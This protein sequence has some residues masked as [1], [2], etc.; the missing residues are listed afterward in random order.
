VQEALQAASIPT[1]MACLVH[2]TGER[3]WIEYP[4]LPKRDIALFADPTGGLPAEVQAQVRDAMARV[5]EELADGRR[6]LA[7]QPDDAT[8]LAVMRTIIAEQIPPEYVTMVREEMGLADR[9]V[10][11]SDERS[12]AP[13]SQRKREDLHVLIIGAAISGLCAAIRLDEMGIRYQIVEKNEEIGG[14]WWENDYPESGV[15]TPNHFYSFSFE[16]NLDW[17]S[18]YSKRGEVLEYLRDIASRR[19]LRRHVR[20]RTEVTA[21][22]WHEDRQQWQASLRDADGNIADYWAPIVITAVGQ[23]NRPKTAP[24]PGMETFTGPS[25]HSARW[26]RDA[27]LA[28]KHVAIIGTGASAMQFLRSV[29]AEAAQ[30]TVFQRSPQWARYEA[31]YHGRVGEAGRWLLRHVPYYYP[32]Y[33][34]GLIW[35][36]GDGLL[37][38]LRRDP[39]WEH[40]ARSMNRRNDRHR[41]VMTQ[42]L[43]SQLEGRD[44]LIAK[45]LPD[46]PPYGKRILVDNGWYEALKRDNVDLVTEAVARIEGPAVITDSGARYT[47]D[48]I[49]LATG[50]EAGKM[51]AP[52][53]IRGRSGTPIRARW[54][55]DDPRAYLGIV[56]ADYPNLFV[57]T[58]PNTGLAHGGSLMFMSECQVR[59][60]CGCLKAMVERGIGALEVREGVQNDYCDRVDAEH[61]ELVWTHPGMRNWYRNPR[62][63]VFGPVPWRLVD[64]W[65]MT[66]EPN[67]P[68]FHV[69]RSPDAVR[70]CA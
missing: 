41:E 59:Y 60:I 11:W 12:A 5:L 44:D 20:F 14:T 40:G 62:G 27:D 54:G 16:P 6:Q 7:P 43:L 9:R 2:I 57:M 46:Y 35:R 56:V 69:T 67:L 3:R 32:W 39:T 51:L 10:H 66:R 1:L 25:W 33:R 53:D 8:M 4:F 17:S 63:R 24:F 34:F 29:A 50:F 64:Y 28:G 36:F 37:H 38:T 13:P 30:V 49:I 15:D 55:D 70:G 61:A 22:R 52:M 21:L 23:L 26:P 68:E 58:G 48:V 45:C 19:D 18:C 42:Y 65:G 31:D 47:P